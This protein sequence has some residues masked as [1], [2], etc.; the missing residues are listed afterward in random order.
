MTDDTDED[1]PPPREN[2]DLLG[3]AEAEQLLK[4]SFDG[5]RLAHAWLFSGPEGIGKATLAYRF[6]RYVLSDGGAAMET[7]PSAGAG[8]FGDDL[9]PDDA[10]QEPGEQG[11]LYV[12]PSHPVFRRIAAGGHSDL[13][14][15]ERTINEKTGKLRSEIVVGD[16][17]LVGNFFHHTAGEGGWRVVVIDCADEMN[18]NAANAVLKVLEEPPPKALLL[19]VSHNPGRLLATIRSRCR[20]L[21][22]QPLAPE[23]V[24]SLVGNWRPELNAQDAQALAT[25]ADG[26]P[27]R[28][29][30][31]ASEGGLELYRDMMALLETLPRLDVT[32][33]HAF[34]ARLGKSGADDAFNT[35]SGLLRWWLARMILA[36]AGGARQSGPAPTGSEQALMDRLGGVVG[37]DRWFEVWEKI[38]RLLTRTGQINLDRKQVVLNVFL[39]IE[40][41]VR[42]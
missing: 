6:A 24:S 41:A 39:T 21:A 3:H 28:A 16:V 37:L 34:G 23:D 18:V 13:M 29:L 31:L 40:N 15:V 20:K 14:S 19:L 27:G 10:A 25:L 35:A 36:A 33:L 17:R 5:S 32:A 11:A 8:L 30:A 9:L 2:P 12:S 22:L 7:E 38:N 4:V 1:I 26:S 42:P